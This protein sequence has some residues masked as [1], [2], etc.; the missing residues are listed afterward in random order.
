MILEANIHGIN[1]YSVDPGIVATPMVKYFGHTIFS[2]ISFYNVSRLLFKNVEQ[3][4]QTIIYCAVDEKIIE[5]TG[6][7]YS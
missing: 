4:A 5:D 7:Y 3:G 6:L 1:I 2:S